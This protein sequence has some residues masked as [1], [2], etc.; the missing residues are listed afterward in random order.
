MRG[1]SSSLPISPQSRF[2]YVGRQKIDNHWTLVLAFAQNSGS[3]KSPGQVEFEGKRIPVF[4]QGV[5]WIEE[6]TFRIVR[7]RTDL[8][9]SLP[10]VHLQRLTAEL[11]FGAIHIS[12]VDSVLWLPREVDTTVD[13]YRQISS[14]AHLYSDYRLYVLRTR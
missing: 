8:L 6:T 1:C 13:L 2:R 9:A 12:R 3:V 4:C 10:S 5:A 11:R 14:E 7:L